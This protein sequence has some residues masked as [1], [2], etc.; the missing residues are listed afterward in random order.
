MD[1]RSQPYVTHPFCVSDLEDAQTYWAEVRPRAV[2]L[3]GSVSG[4]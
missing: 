1:R 3:D 4:F 2:S